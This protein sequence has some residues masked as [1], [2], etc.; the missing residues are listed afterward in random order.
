M[1][2]ATAQYSHS[3]YSFTHLRP[4][5]R[6]SLSHCSPFMYPPTQPHLLFGHECVLLASKAN[7]HHIFHPSILANVKCPRRA[8]A[9]S[10][11]MD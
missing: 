8:L 1:I 6:P 4:H 7:K 9:D 10:Y 3:D 5:N 2:L 11:D